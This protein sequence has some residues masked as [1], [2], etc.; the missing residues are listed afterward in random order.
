MNDTAENGTGWGSR[1]VGG[2][3][4]SGGE[5]AA[6]LGH[7]LAAAGPAGRAAAVVTGHATSRTPRARLARLVD[8]AQR[9]FRSACG[10]AFSR[11]AARP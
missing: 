6:S 11:A 3:Q 4:V 1:L 7:G 10:G 2:I 5:I 9:L 8:T